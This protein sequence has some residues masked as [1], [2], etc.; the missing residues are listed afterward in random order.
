[1]LGLLEVSSQLAKEHVDIV[2]PGFTH[3]QPAQPIRFSH[4]VLS[5]TAALERDCDRLHDIIKRT[6]KFCPLGSG[7]LAGKKC[8]HCGDVVAEA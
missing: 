6:S 2:M 5:H 1:M 4:W 7:A 3:L 8:R